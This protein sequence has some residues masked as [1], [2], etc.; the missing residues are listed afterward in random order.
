MTTKLYVLA[1]AGGLGMAASFNTRAPACGLVVQNSLDSLAQQAV[2]KDKTVSSVAI[3]K[4]RA[5]GPEGLEALLKAH[6]E[7]IHKH[8]SE[9]G[10]S[11]V[12]KQETYWKQ[13][14]TALDA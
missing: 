6:A 14:K 5:K 9:T 4:L 3:T 12:Q 2:S 7:M 10:P 8:L 11:S 13:G 1:V